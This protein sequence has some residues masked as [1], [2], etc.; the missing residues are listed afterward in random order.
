MNR[1]T[2]SV[3]IRRRRACDPLDLIDPKHTILARIGVLDDVEMGADRL[4][5]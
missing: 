3:T 2:W 1:W 4:D 5:R